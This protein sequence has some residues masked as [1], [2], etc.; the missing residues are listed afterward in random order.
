MTEADLK[1]SLGIDKD[2]G[3]FMLLRE[4]HSG[5]QTAWDCPDAW[6]SET[7]RI[8]DR[9]KAEPQ[10]LRW[11]QWVGVHALASQFLAS[12]PAQ[13]P[14]GALLADEVGVGKTAQMFGLI[15]YFN[16]IA[17]LKQSGKELPPLLSEC[18]NPF[19][20]WVVYVRR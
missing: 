8:I 10:D 17:E 7:G 20:I 9:S 14:V 12:E 5:G 11:V 4:R 1:A 3:L 6:D 18:L 2:H 19:L 16:Y 13:Q 15:A